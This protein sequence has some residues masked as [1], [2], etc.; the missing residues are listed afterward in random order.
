MLGMF[1]DTLH[2]GPIGALGVDIRQPCANEGV[3]AREGDPTKSAVTYP[4]P[5]PNRVMRQFGLQQLIPGPPLQPSNIH[6]LTL[7][8][9]NGHNSRRLL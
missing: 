4:R 6:G 1:L 5:Q 9:K 8:G 3:P 2:G 7:K